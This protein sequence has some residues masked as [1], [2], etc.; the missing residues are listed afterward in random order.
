MSHRRDLTTLL[1]ELCSTQ[2]THTLSH[3]S[4]CCCCDQISPAM[5]ACLAQY[6]VWSHLRQNSHTSRGSTVH[7]VHQRIG[8]CNGNGPSQPQQGKVKES[9]PSAWYADT[10][11]SGQLDTNTNDK[12][13]RDW[14]LKS[15]S[16]L[17]LYPNA[18][19]SQT[20]KQFHSL[21]YRSLPLTP[22]CFRR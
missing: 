8:P 20:I 13:T 22:G 15:L 3:W 2:K 9:L 4:F 16:V 17:L 12:E 21:L 1:Q 10:N 11:I 6:G 7:E 14:S 19:V 5:I 18:R